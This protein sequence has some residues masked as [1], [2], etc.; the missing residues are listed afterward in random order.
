MVV[1][2][3]LV[4]VDVL[5]VVVGHALGLAMVSVSEPLAPLDHTAL[6]VKLGAGPDRLWVVV[7]TNAISSFWEGWPLTDQVSGRLASARAVHVT[8]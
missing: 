4:V 3:V 1:E 2:E 5:V 6:T 8:V 7:N